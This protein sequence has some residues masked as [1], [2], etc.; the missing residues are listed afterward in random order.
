MSTSASEL[1]AP[2]AIDVRF[3]SECL[4]VDLDDG[5]SISVPISWYPRLCNATDVERS[6]WEIF[7]RTGIHWPDIDE[8][9][10]VLALLS[11]NRSNESQSSLRQWLSNRAPADS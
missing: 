11:G 4:V 5:R 6:N 2:T 3:E 9:I 8:D 1:T 7:G 10:S